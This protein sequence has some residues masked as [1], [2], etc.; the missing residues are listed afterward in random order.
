MVPDGILPLNHARTLISCTTKGLRAEIKT[1]RPAVQSPWVLLATDKGVN[2]VDA[3][4]G[5]QS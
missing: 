4:Y 3:D 1:P 2:P 5:A